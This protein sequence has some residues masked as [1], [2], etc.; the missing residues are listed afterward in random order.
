ML[1]AFSGQQEASH[2]NWLAEC[3]RLMADRS[4]LCGLK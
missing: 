1:S 4:N 3:L 2:R